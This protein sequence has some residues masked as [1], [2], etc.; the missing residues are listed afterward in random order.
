MGIVKAIVHGQHR[1]YD[2]PV[3]TQALPLYL[4]LLTALKDQ[5]FLPLTSTVNENA[6]NQ[7]PVFQFLGAGFHGDSYQ[8]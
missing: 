2:I 6:T 8:D 7:S 5:T 1:L 4:P 3:L